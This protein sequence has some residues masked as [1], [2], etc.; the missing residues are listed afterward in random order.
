MPSEQ[1][2]TNTPTNTPTDTSVAA[3]TEPRPEDPP[4]VRPDRASEVT[5][6]SQR[7]SD[8]PLA[9]LAEATREGSNAPRAAEGPSAAPADAPVPERAGSAK[10]SDPTLPEADQLTRPERERALPGDRAAG[11][12]L[13][14]APAS[15]TSAPPIPPPTPAAPQPG[16]PDAL[17]VTSSTAP[18]DPLARGEAVPRPPES[19]DPALDVLVPAIS[20]PVPM[21]LLEHLIPS[22]PSSASALRS[23]R[24]QRGANGTG[25]G[26]GGGGGVGRKAGIESDRESMSFSLKDPI[27]IRPGQPAASQGLR[28][29]TVDIDI[30]TTARVATRR[31]AWAEV[32][33]KFNRDGVVIFADFIDGKTTG[34]ADWDGPVLDAV[35]RWVASGEMLNQLPPDPFTQPG[36]RPVRAATPGEADA[37]PGLWAVL[38]VFLD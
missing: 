12:P 8:D 30:S 11:S 9:K 3:P 16:T 15:A 18:A 33:V 21:Y 5:P 6:A 4:K 25:G 26:G 29:R 19:S 10:E 27:R 13:P 20:A 32:R 22:G 1:P 36:R 23:A 31:N 2:P 34:H 35:Y 7:P 14:E 38:R 37:R 17:D 24:P 28:I